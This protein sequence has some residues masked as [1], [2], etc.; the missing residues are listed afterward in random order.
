MKYSLPTPSSLTVHTSL[1][2]RKRWYVDGLCVLDDESPDFLHEIFRRRILFVGARCNEQVAARLEALKALAAMDRFEFD[3][4]VK[5]F[6][7]DDRRI[8]RRVARNGVWKLQQ[9]QY[10]LLRVV[11]DDVAMK[12]GLMNHYGVRW[13]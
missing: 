10:G 2:R 7:G 4:A 1:S 12:L 5:S 3:K 8:L 13:L 9:E 11:L 6:V